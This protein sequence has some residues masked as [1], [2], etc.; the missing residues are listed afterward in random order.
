[1]YMVRLYEAR[2]D[3]DELLRNRTNTR[4]RNSR[5][6]IHKNLFS[7]ML[8]QVIIRLIVYFDQAL[9]RNKLG[10]PSLNFNET[11]HG[12]DNM[13]YVCESTYVLLE[14]A[15]SVMFMWIFVEGLYLH[16]VVTTNVLREK[17][18][19]CWY[20]AMGWG[21][22]ILITSVWAVATAFYYD[23]FENMKTALINASHYESCNFPSQH[24]IKMVILDL[25][26]RDLE[27]E[28]Q[29][30]AGL[31]KE[32]GGFCRS[33]CMTGLPRLFISQFICKMENEETR[34]NSLHINLRGKKAVRAT[35]VLLPLLNHQCA[36]HDRS[37]I[38]RSRSAVRYMELRHALLQV[39]SR[40][41]SSL[42]SIAFERRGE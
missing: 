19:F 17:I 11:V 21:C 23:E 22:P 5:T 27:A 34:L 40:D 41:S 3:R 36:E 14:Y 7:A 31:R 20:Y 29:R 13:P 2:T 25:K 6:R 38:R 24:F 42:A 32:Y 30:L 8:V 12:I 37:A 15:I 26:S 9:I 1:M 33:M 4:L 39:L 10:D 16:N 18:S 28:I 35:L